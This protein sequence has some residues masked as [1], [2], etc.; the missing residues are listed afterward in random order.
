MN[1]VLDTNI[2]VSAALTPKGKADGVLGIIFDNAQIQLDSCDI[3]IA[4]YRR[5]LSKPRLSIAPEVQ[6]EILESIKND[7]RYV[8]PEMS[9]IPFT[10]EDD[11]IFY[12]AA[13]CADAYLI[14]GNKKHYPKERFILNPAEFLELEINVERGGAYEK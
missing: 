12:D 2:L 5:V 4:E 6:F 3:I 14:T 11:R 13:K 1:V 8:K 10:H 9:K 7:G